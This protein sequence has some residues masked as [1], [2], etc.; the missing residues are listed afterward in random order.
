MVAA[1]IDLPSSSPMPPV[2]RQR[3][4]TERPAKSAAQ[5]RQDLAEK[6]G[7]HERLL[8]ALEAIEVPDCRCKLSMTPV[9]LILRQHGCRERRS[10]GA[11]QCRIRE[12]PSCQLQHKGGCALRRE[13]K[14]CCCKLAEMPECLS[15]GCNRRQ[16]GK[17]CECPRWP[18]EPCQHVTSL[19]ARMIF[20]AAA[21]ILQ[22]TAGNDEDID[23]RWCSLLYWLFPK[24]YRGPRKL[25]APA[26]LIDRQTRV[27]RMRLRRTWRV[28][29]YHPADVRYLPGDDDQFARRL[30]RNATA[31]ARLLETERKAVR[32]G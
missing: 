12:L 26:N 1:L 5:K 14:P 15:P 6:F 31:F 2:S 8:I 4:S 13:G 16:R 10:T 25:P 21:T 22:A 9:C 20:Q 18:G 32:H 19:T 3:T 7:V 28:Q 24:P 30:S 27:E 17:L 11:C 29:L 23:S